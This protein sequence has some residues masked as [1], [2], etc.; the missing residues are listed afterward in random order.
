M[1]EA[2]SKY[3]GRLGPGMIGLLLVAVNLAQPESLAALTC[4]RRRRHTDEAL[5][6]PKATHK[7]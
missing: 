6:R 5:E 3:V 7:E 1:A 2:N 4:A